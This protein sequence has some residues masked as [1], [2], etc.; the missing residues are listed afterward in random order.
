MIP[1]RRTPASQNGN[2]EPWPE[3]QINQ[4]VNT[5]KLKSSAKI[6]S[7]GPKMSII[8][9]EAPNPGFKT[10][11]PSPSTSKITNPSQI[12]NNG[13]PK[14]PNRDHPVPQKKLCQV[15]IQSLAKSFILTISE[16]RQTAVPFAGFSEFGTRNWTW[17]S[18]GWGSRLWSW[19]SMFEFSARGFPYSISKTS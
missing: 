14:I 13:K 2:R 18:W 19:R 11:N 3:W 8:S 9:H 10:S 16:F 6:S 4:K 17:R 15:S 5:T 1:K 7:P 12:T